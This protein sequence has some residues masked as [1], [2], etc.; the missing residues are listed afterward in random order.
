M[1]ENLLEEA[2]DASDSNFGTTVHQQEMMNV[3]LDSACTGK[4]KACLA[5]VL[6]LLL[7]K[8]QDPNQ[9]IRL[10]Q[11]KFPGGFS[12]RTLDTNI[13]TPFL[14]GQDFPYMKSGS[15]WLTRSFEQSG[16][17]NLDYSGS[18]R[19]PELKR[20]FL[21]FVEEIQC[22][23][24]DPRSFIRYVLKKLV[25]WRTRNANLTLP[26]P[27]NRR[28]EDIVQTV[29]QHWNCNLPGVSKLPVLAIYAAYECLVS[30]LAKFAGCE[31]M[32][33]EI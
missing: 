29:T 30:E 24:S 2:I 8:H 27:T 23:D 31:L 14:R 13:V 7:K 15:G 16:P 28:I 5:V 17:F 26:R 11:T 33:L 20:A 22:G 1:L 4:Q 32:R 9:D 18:M 10:H 12:G 21:E 19:A 3:I 25:E 6:T